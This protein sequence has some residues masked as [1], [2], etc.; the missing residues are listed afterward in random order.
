[1]E[2]LTSGSGNVIIAPV[3]QLNLPMSSSQATENTTKNSYEA[4]LVN[5]RKVT[6]PITHLPVTI[7]DSTS[8][9]LERIPPPYSDSK[10]TEGLNSK[11]V[12]SQRHTGIE[13]VVLEETNKGWWEEDN[14]GRTRTA[15]ITASSVSIG[16]YSTL[17]LSKLLG[18]IFGTSSEGFSVLDLFIGSVGCT[19]LAVV[20]AFLILHHDTEDVKKHDEVNCSLSFM[21]ISQIPLS[22][23]AS[24]SRS[25]ARKA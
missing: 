18:R 20:A 21:P 22:S 24:E 1:M 9:Q 3:I 17:I 2:H 19:L 10:A 12:N 23:E 6:D 11:E 16:G 4:P 13:Q 8:I 5:E 15:F 7:H 14:S 25:Y